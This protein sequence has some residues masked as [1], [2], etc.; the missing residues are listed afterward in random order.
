M[1][2][3]FI[4]SMLPTAVKWNRYLYFF[5]PCRSLKYSV[6][7]NEIS[8]IVADFSFLHLPDQYRQVLYPFSHI[9][10]Q[11]IIYQNTNG[12]VT[13]DV[14]HQNIEIWTTI[15]IFFLETSR[16]PFLLQSLFHMFAIKNFMLLQFIFL[17]LRLSQKCL[18]MNQLFIFKSDILW[19]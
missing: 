9:L 2:E 15:Q 18:D 1:N 16:F 14:E 12:V 6:K 4:F 7:F 13:T 17:L 10:S 8:H 11:V 3:H 19:T 5:T